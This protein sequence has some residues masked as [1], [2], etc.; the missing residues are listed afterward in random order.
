MLGVYLPFWPVWLSAQGLD[1]AQV[2]LLVAVTL[3]TK[4]LGLP[5][6]AWLA[7]SWGRTTQ[8]MAVCAGLSI[9][10]FAGFFAA[11]GFA[12]ILFIQVL[13]ALSFQA[14]IPLGESH[15]LRAVPRLGLNY[16]RVRLWGS[17]S[18]IAGSLLGGFL[19]SRDLTGGLLWALIGALF[20][21]LLA[22]LALPPLAAPPKETAPS[23]RRA[24]ALLTDPTFALLLVCAG[25]LQASHAVYYG[26]SA[27]SWQAADISG[28]AIGWLWAVGVVA[29]ILLFTVGDRL[30]GR[31]GPARLLGAAALAGAVR[32]TVLAVTADLVVLTVAQCLHGLTFGAAHLA[33]VHLLARRAPRRLSATA[34]GL[35]S[36]ISGG[37]IMGLAV[38][39]AGQLYAGFEAK[40]YFAMVLLSLAAW[41]LSRALRNRGEEPD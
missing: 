18:F 14:L 15:T 37:V 26:F 12:A 28:L 5:A 13:A 3:W 19:V 38:F 33:T 30:V 29:E 40:A 35:Y 8:A 32:W 9:A 7:D 6:V 11:E 31:Y 39:A 17:L 34:Q 21:G 2:G 41:P 1:A 24:L 25:L 22:A 10:A 20:L 27:I 36:A 16:G 23:P 4:V